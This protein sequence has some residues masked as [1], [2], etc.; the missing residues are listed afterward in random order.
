MANPV[1]AIPEGHPTITP[2]L[3]CKDAAR[4]I[5]FYKQVF[6]AKELMR[7]EGPGG[8]IGHAELT[9]GNSKIMLNDE[10]PGMAIAPSGCTGH[11]LYVYVE[12]C[13]AV[14]N[15]AV[16]AGARADM[17]AT[18]MFWGDRYGKFTDPFGHQW[19]VATHVEDVAPAEMDRRA[20]EWKAQAAGQS[21]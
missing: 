12:D 11:S 10:F 5:D 13:D 20:K 1:K 17:P 15:R 9:I 19:G 4:A 8:S 21:N 3:T 16:A 7:M 2:G 14:F 18:N 6:G